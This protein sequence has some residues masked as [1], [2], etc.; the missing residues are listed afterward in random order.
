MPKLIVLFYGAE[1]PAVALA[2]AAA[3]GAQRVRFTEVDIRAG[4]GHPETTATRHK[5]LASAAE[6]RDYD[7]VILA[8][9]AAGDPPAAL[10]RMLDALDREA[11]DAFADRVF[12][13]A[14]AENT[15][16]LGHVARLGGIIVAEP[17]GENDPEERAR[18][19]GGK[20][21]TV[22]GWVRHALSHEQH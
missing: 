18:R 5:R 9:P 21:A 1:T 15:V 6:I 12:G 17:R 8:C 20:V 7:G 10:R 16:L 19:L 14:G 4:A 13:V 11:V 3:E 2:E 22:V